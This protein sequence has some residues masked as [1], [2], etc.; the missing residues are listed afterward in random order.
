LFYSTLH[1]NT[2]NGILAFLLL[3]L[4]FLF[5]L[6]NTVYCCISFDINIFFYFFCFSL[7]TTTNLNST[8]IQDKFVLHGYLPICCNLCVASRKQKLKTNLLRNYCLMYSYVKLVG[9]RKKGLFCKTKC[10]RELFLIKNPG[11]R[12]WCTFLQLIS[13]V[14]LK[15]KL[16][17]ILQIFGLAIFRRTGCNMWSN[18]DSKPSKKIEWF[19]RSF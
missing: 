10:G 18:G 1:T 4:L 9:W 17:T 5:L 12:A 15:L 16:I 13:Y 3:I 6:L 11:R 19:P 14:Y 8:W 7:F 2:L